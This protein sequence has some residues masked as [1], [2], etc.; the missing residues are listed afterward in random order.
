MK[1]LADVM[2]ANL[3]R[4]LR[5]FGFD[6]ACAKND[7]KDRELVEIAH[8]EGRVLLTRDKKLANKP[9]SLLLKSTT[10]GEQLKEIQKGFNLQITFPAKT[11]C[12]LCN[13]E[14]N[15]VPCEK[16]ADKVPEKTKSDKFWLC[17]SCGKVY[18]RGA[19]WK[20]IE[21]MADELNR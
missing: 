2:V 7:Q 19:H 12:A 10:V 15:E 5:I 3:A 18:W 21:E 20:K 8:K 9:N 14:L 6:T 16:V 1:F 11:R 13:G 4:W 17:K